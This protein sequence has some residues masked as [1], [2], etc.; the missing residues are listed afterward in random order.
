[1]GTHIMSPPDY[2]A[3]KC[4]GGMGN[5]CKFVTD[6]YARVLGFFFTIDGR[7]SIAD[8]RRLLSCCICRFCRN[9]ALFWFFSAWRLPVV[10]G[11]SVLCFG[12]VERGYRYPLPGAVR[13]RCVG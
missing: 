8:V 7:G 4:L 13:G 9:R 12:Y 10:S 11:W 6:R 2:C 5:L 1:G 3:I